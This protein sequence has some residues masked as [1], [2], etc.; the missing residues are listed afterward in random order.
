MLHAVT[1]WEFPEGEKMKQSPMMERVFFLCF[2]GVVF[3]WGGGF[4]LLCH[5]QQCSRHTPGTVLRHHSS[6]VQK[7]IWDAG[8]QTLVSCVQSKCTTNYSI[9]L[10]PKWKVLVWMKLCFVV[11]NDTK[12]RLK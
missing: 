10:A 5:T 4:W 3:F 9:L 6:Q 2:C 12:M 1:T 8:N 7:T 11:E